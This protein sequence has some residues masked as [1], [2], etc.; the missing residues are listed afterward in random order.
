MKNMCLMEMRI[1]SLDPRREAS[2]LML[3]LKFE[4]GVILR[5]IILVVA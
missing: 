4:T 5:Q 2:L 3:D 1:P